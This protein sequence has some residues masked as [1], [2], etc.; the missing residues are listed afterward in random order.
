MRRLINAIINWLSARLVGEIA[1]PD[2]GL[3]F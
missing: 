1:P 3:W 2:D